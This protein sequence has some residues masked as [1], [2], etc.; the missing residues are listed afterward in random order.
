MYDK[1]L[2]DKFI[3]DYLLKQIR[4]NYYKFSLSPEIYIDKI[5]Y[6]LSDKF[7]E[8]LE[9][10]DTD[11]NFEIFQRKLMREILNLKIYFKKRENLQ[12]TNTFNNF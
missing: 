9:S 6:N 2:I 3:N 12:C 1:V 7:I 5:V 10:L 8:E 11:F 4:K